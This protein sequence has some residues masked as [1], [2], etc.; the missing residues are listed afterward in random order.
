MGERIKGTPRI[1]T[2]QAHLLVVTPDREE[3]T[4]WAPADALDPEPRII[5]RVRRQLVPVRRKHMQLVLV[6]SGCESWI[7][8]SS[9]EDITS[10]MLSQATM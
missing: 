1:V 8:I 6:G 5:G 9:P 2:K 10:N 7:S 3:V 4:V